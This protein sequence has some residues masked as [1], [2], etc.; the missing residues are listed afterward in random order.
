MIVPMLKYTFLVYHKE[1][2][3][4]LKEL[5]KLGLV[6]V[7]EKTVEET[8]T[9][10]EK[11]ALLGE[12][13]SGISFLKKRNIPASDTV[14]G[15]ALDLLQKIRS[16]TDEK[17]KN[18]QQ[19]QA[20]KKEITLLEPWGNFRPEDIKKLQEAS[21]TLRFF[22]CSQ[23]KFNDNW[24]SQYNI[25]II[26]EQAGNIYFV[27][28]T[29]NSEPVEIDAEE[30]KLP[31][32]PLNDLLKQYNEIEARNKAIEESLD[33][34]AKAV[35]LLEVLKK[36]IFAEIEYEKVLLNTGKE[37]EERL[38]LLE[39]WIPE[40][41]SDALS[42]FCDTNGILY[43][44]DKPSDA[45]SVPVLLKN[46]KFAR[47]YEPILKLY[48]LPAYYEI[49]LTAFFAPF[50]MIF[51][52][53]CLGD[54]GYGLTIL[55]LV[56]LYKIFKA[57]PE[58]K[59]LL[60]L[61]QYLGAATVLM[62]MVSG[63]V[64]GVN[65]LDTGYLLT[66]QSLEFLRGNNLPQEL[67]DKISSVVG[68]HFETR[69]EFFKA[70][71]GLIGNDALKNYKLELMRCSFSDYAILNKFRHLILDSQSMFNLALAF[72]MFQ[73]LFGMGMRAANMIKQ[74]G[75]IYAVST[76]SWI[77]L[78]VGLII[79]QG[80]ALMGYFEKDA[81][82]LPTYI[83]LGTGL[84]GILFFND[85]STNIFISFGKGLYDIYSM[86]TGVFGDLLSYIRLFALGTS[87]AILG[88][89]IDKIAVQF[90]GVSYIGPV[91]FVIFLLLGHTLVLL[92]SALG[93]FVHP[94]RLTFVEFFKNSGFSG[95]GKEYKPFTN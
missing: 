67:L 36:Q 10:R 13:D 82:K 65:L 43:I 32:T 5:G 87:G 61:G 3:R 78:I 68:R 70:L 53:F 85:P 27:V 16:L 55:L 63:T 8:E 11:K 84:F 22:T 93:A 47:L 51:F 7:I 29:E 83:I 31:V 79:T 4:F 40:E 9:L 50:F 81:V 75:A 72:G 74:K 48:S 20:I 21:L 64:F 73:I 15:D 69:D 34:A 54:A 76:I 2:E 60:T 89:V 92:L 24:K 1:Y 46:N 38:M 88:L 26:H 52:G 44:T 37:A 86:V 12:V 90:M 17:E 77:V 71:T 35:S 41:K 23:R 49:D 19:Q 25:E 58:I 42:E 91:L 28:I 62:G 66:E 57:K 14:S 30:V 33:E 80:G 45:D 18:K 94:L 6:H 39:G 95:G 56:T 59:P